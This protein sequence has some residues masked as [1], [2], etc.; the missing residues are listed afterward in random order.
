MKSAI[1][2]LLCLSLTS[3]AAAS[4]L[5]ANTVDVSPADRSQPERFDDGRTR[6]ALTVNGDMNVQYRVM[7]VSALPGD[8]LTLSVPSGVMLNSRIPVERLNGRDMSWTAPNSPGHHT[9]T[10]T[11][12]DGETI[13]LNIF[14]LRPAA[15]IE[16]GVLE[17][18]RIGDY[19]DAPY[20]GLDVYRAPR[21]FIEVT[22][23]MTTMEI[24]PHFTL[25][26]FLCKQAGGWPRYAVVQERLLIKLERILAEVNR[27][28]WRT[29]GFVMMSGYRTPAYNAGIGNGRHSRHVY[30]GAADIY[31]DT[32]GDG[33]MDDLNADGHLDRAD[34]AVLYDFID[35][36]LNRPDW[37]D[38]H[39]GLG[40]YGSTSA[41][42]PFVHVDER[43]WNARWGRN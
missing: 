33:V 39:G 24:A 30:G 7:S 19:P 17:G 1:T 15:E 4:D 13:T 37:Q 35:G 34:A 11:A 28:G 18:Y 38:F 12:A 36:L 5:A 23:E 20:R 22:P 27:A 29:D 41:H 26:Q 3:A 32:D 40:E 43:G 2:S 14:V 31:I 9:I 21:G 10:A 42:G 6:F 16:D 8:R 25:G